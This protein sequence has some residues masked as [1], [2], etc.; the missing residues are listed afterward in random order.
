MICGVV[1]TVAPLVP[2]RPVYVVSADGTLFG[3]HSPDAATRVLGFRRREDAVALA[4]GLQ[5]YHDDHGAF[6]PRDI[7]A[8]DLRALIPRVDPDA[9]PSLTVVGVQ[10][11]TIPVMLERM[12]GTYLIMALLDE[13]ADGKRGWRYVRPVSTKAANVHALNRTWTMTYGTFLKPKPTRGGTVTTTDDDTGG[14]QGG[15]GTGTG[16]GHGT[17]TTQGDTGTGTDQGSASG[18]LAALVDGLADG[19]TDGVGDALAGEFGKE[20][21]SVPLMLLAS[22][23]FKV[24]VMIE[25]TSVLHWAGLGSKD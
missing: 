6:P 16:H 2:S 25:V 8:R 7:R 9:P 17:G 20:G 11:V 14:T 21:P 15:T 12:F 13:D 10:A 23:L 24:L 3:L 4:S 19:V 18:F 22:T 1:G 5:K